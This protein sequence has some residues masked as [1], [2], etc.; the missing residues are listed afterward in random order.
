MA[1]KRF[2]R[3]ATLQMSRRDT[4]VDALRETIQSGELP[5]GE[6]LSLDEIAN[7]FGVSRMPVREALKQLE[8]EGL[9]KFYPYRGV[10]V[11]VLAPDD[12]DELFSIRSALEQMALERAVLRLSAEQL[13]EMHTTLKKMDDTEGWGD[14]LELNHR[15][16]HTINEA[17]GWPR[18]VEM[19][20]MLRVNVERYVRA[21][22][23]I[24]GREKSRNQHWALYEACLNRDVERAK[25]VIAEHLSD[26][27]S[28]LYASLNRQ[29]Q[30]KARPARRRTARLRTD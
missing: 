15:F 10:E 8:S 27:S 25:A 26:T 13:E 11:S 20:E 21:Y 6:R 5:A 24:Q 29:A 17:S 7:E 16:H 14:W 19:I 22:L 1:E 12:L 23:S 18:L 4:I 28:A 2:S 3:F 30:N 9:V